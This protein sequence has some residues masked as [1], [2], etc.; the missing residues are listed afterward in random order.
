MEQI[1]VNGVAQGAQYALLA[2][3]FWVIFAVT[4]TFHLAHVVVLNVTAYVL[5]WAFVR[6]GIPLWPSIG[7]ALVAAVALGLLI[8]TA[9]YAPVRRGGGDQLLLFLAASAI[10]TIGQAG[11]ALLFGE[12]ALGVT[13]GLPSDWLHNSSFVVTTYDGMS[14]V[15]VLAAGAVVWLMMSRMRWGRAMRAVQDNPSLAGNFG[16][17]VARTYR[18]AFAIGSALVVP[19]A[20]LMALQAGVNPD[21]GFQPV[22]I[23][24]IAVIAGGTER[25]SG[26][27]LAA[28]LIG[29]G[30]NI[31]LE[32]V[33]A[34]WQTII[35]F[36][37]LALLLIGRPSGLRAAVRTREA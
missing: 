27:M 20:V 17:P 33:P 12:N 25:Q 18:I 31:V 5:Y 11:L 3:S 13:Q 23:A 24:I 30:E 2:L 9:V 28:F 6:L 32:W 37:A 1:I 26:A 7:L 14:V 36:G 10:L 29:L 4:R 21:F 34:E 35:V 15:C 16:I 19:A 8:E 22:L